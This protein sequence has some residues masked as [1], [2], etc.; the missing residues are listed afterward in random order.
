MKKIDISNKLILIFFLVTTIIFF[1]K[2]IIFNNQNNLKIN[3]ENAIKT[4]KLGDIENQ[5]TESS[6]EPNKD[7]IM[8]SK[9]YTFSRNDLLVENHALLSSNPFVDFSEIEEK[10]KETLEVSFSKERLDGR[11]KFHKG[12]GIIYVTSESNE[13]F[14]I[15]LTS[16]KYAFGCGLKVQ[17]D[18]NKIRKLNIPLA[19]YTKEEIVVDKLVS[20]YYLS[21]ENGLL[22]M[23]DFDSFYY[24][25]GYIDEIYADKRISGCRGL[26]ALVKDGKVVAVSTDQ[27]TAN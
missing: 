18:E 16:D 1:M 7:E 13:T 11:L 9:D 10:C 6:N 3:N 14:C 24:M 25:Q 19:K 12:D 5:L 17:M 8:N 27:P 15:I 26:I 20:S 23:F 2:I 4:E 21:C 22:S